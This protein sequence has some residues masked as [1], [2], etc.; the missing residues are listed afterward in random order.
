MAGSLRSKF[1]TGELGDN[2]FDRTGFRHFKFN[3]I[4]HKLGKIAAILLCAFSGGATGNFIQFFFGDS[5][6]ATLYSQGKGCRICFYIKVTQMKLVFAGS[7]KC[8]FFDCDA[9]FR[10]VSGKKFSAGRSVAVPAG[11]VRFN[12]PSTVD[13]KRFGFQQDTAGG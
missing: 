13:F 1:T 2:D 8:N 12:L 10:R 11:E 3:I 5:F 9:R 4:P 7:G 6:S